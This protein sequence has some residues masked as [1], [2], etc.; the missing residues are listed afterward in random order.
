MTDTVPAT[1]IG[2]LLAAL[3]LSMLAAL[4]W[5]RP[6]GSA[7]SEARIE[8]L[9]T[10][11]VELQQELVSTRLRAET[12]EA[13][14]AAA[15]ARVEES[16]VSAASQLRLIDEARERLA[17]TFRSAAVDALR[18]NRSEFLASAEEQL[19]PLRQVLDQYQRK[20]AEV[21]EQR[22][23]ELG[24][25]GEQYRELAA[26]A[27]GLQ[28][29]TTKLV[30]ALRSPHVRGRWGQMTLRRTAEL[31]G[32]VA[33]CDFFEQESV[34]TEVG[35]A[36]PDM[37]VN[38]PNRRQVI[39][40]SKVPLAGYLDAIA[41]TSDGERDA[42]LDRHAAQTKVHVTQLASKEYQSHFAESPDFV[43]M[44]IPN[45]SFLAAAAERMPDL[46]DFALTRNVVIATP[47][48]FVALLRTIEFGW[49]QAHLA[50]GA[51]QVS[52]LGQALSERLATFVDHLDRVGS[53][54]R[55]AVESYNAAVSSLETRVLPAARRF[56]DLGVTGAKELAELQPVD[57]A[58][59]AV[60]TPF[61]PEGAQAMFSDDLSEGGLG[62]SRSLPPAGS[63]SDER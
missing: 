54:L 38:L 19:L 23:R 27:S 22:Q 48:T 29:E 12:A 51:K 7:A 18:G 31:A 14:R 37:R 52:L 33:Y 6:A 58:T 26:V 57:V 8:E 62:A 56:R 3:A 34:T 17:E 35:R 40:D 42:A 16:A 61:V 30:S 4:M 44:F 13:Q 45:D 10:R 15:A 46:V 36:S 47:A 2:V 60:A 21:E 1:F 39:V 24:Q 55:R 32:M 43:V 20:T 5:R 25:V 41:A 53:G 59:R 28:R 50:E 63:P 49:R 9:R 11:I